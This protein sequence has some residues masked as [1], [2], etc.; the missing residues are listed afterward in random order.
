MI[1]AGIQ[2]TPNNRV[3]KGRRRGGEAETR[4]GAKEEDEE[5]EEGATADACIY[6]RA[7]IVARTRAH[8]YAC[9]KH[10]TCTPRT[11]SKHTRSHGNVERRS[12]RSARFL[13]SVCRASWVPSLRSYDVP[14]EL[15]VP[16]LSLRIRVTLS[17]SLTCSRSHPIYSRR[18]TLFNYSSHRARN[19][20]N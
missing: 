12:S 17:R 6:M 5:E 2:M 1:H 4:N 10:A 18:E 11:R 20:S 16:P 19:S 3:L 7:A 8:S 13:A 9:V 15:T 14:T